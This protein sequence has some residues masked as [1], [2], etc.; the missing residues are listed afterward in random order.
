MEEFDTFDS[1]YRAVV[2]AFVN[3]EHSRNSGRGFG[4]VEMI[5]GTFIVRNPRER[6]VRVPSRNYNLAFCLAEFIWYM[7]GRD[8]FQFLEPYAPGMLQYS[9]NGRFTGTAYGP[10]VCGRSPSGASRWD[11]VIQTI[12]RD[13]ETKRAFLQIF[14][15]DELADPS[16][17]DVSCTI[18]LH[19]LLRDD[20]LECVALM[21]ANDAFRGIVSDVFSFTMMQEL[22]S[23]E[24]GIALG[25][26][27]H[28]ASSLHLYDPDVGRA[29]IVAADSGA[30]SNTPFPAMPDCSNR[31]AIKVVESVVALSDSQLAD[32]DRAIVCDLLDLH[33]YWQGVGLVLLSGRADPR[34]LTGALYNDRV[35]RLFREIALAA[36]AR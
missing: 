13:A 4:S 21:R 24:L 15:S 9:R 2:R 3:G 8:D 32:T 28:F 31:D 36:I 16:N 17:P 6:S 35:P 26:Y 29:R 25:K 7:T 20:R 33:P 18:G 30:T 10:R 27:V 23:T 5:P 22:A 34:A 11:D 1:A 19:F 12:R 14:Q